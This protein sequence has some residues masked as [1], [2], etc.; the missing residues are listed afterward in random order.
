[1][2]KRDVNTR[3]RVNCSYSTGSPLPPRCL[4]TVTRGKRHVAV[5]ELWNEHEGFEETRPGSQVVIT[6]GQAGGDLS[7]EEEY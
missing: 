7:S 6:L 2:K 1:M 5:V 3:Y 4:F